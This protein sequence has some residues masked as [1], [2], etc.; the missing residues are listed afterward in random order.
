MTTCV[1][2]IAR[3]CAIDFRRAISKRTAQNEESA[4]STDAGMA[5]NPRI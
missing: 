1:F 3:N 5:T 4:W 2:E